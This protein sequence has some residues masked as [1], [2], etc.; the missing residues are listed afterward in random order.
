MT[1]PE[2]NLSAAI[3]ALQEI[4]SFE[5]TDTACCFC[6]R[7]PFME[8]TASCPIT[9]ARKALLTDKLQP[10]LDRVAEMI[11]A[12]SIK[13]KY[14]PYTALIGIDI[15]MVTGPGFRTISIDGDEHRVIFKADC[16]LEDDEI[17]VI[18]DI[19]RPY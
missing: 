12:L 14:G 7:P 18:E 3:T 13:G 9:I 4:L 5:R 15:L 8:H 6:S 19:K 11:Q 10:I 2:F 17:K 1:V 16:G